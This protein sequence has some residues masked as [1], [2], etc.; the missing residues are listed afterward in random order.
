LRSDLAASTLADDFLIDGEGIPNAVLK[1]GFATDTA[2]SLR[3]TL[4]SLKSSAQ[5]KMRVIDNLPVRR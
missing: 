3:V 5:E 1:Q 4:S 2:M